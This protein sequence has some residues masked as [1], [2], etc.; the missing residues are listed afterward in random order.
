MAPMNLP[1]TA[2]RVDLPVSRGPRYRAAMCAL[3]AALSIGGPAAAVPPGSTTAAESLAQCERA[4]DLTGEQR[5]QALARGMA[6]AEEALAADDHDAR[7]H[8]ATVCNLGKQMED[9]GLGIGQLISLPRLRRSMD[10]AIELAPGDPDA[11]VAKGALLLELPRLFG[12]DRATAETLLRRALAAEPD[13]NTAR[14]FLARALAQR[15]ADDEARA[16]SPHC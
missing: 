8:Y 2:S 13:N 5:A 12:G 3:V 7:A 16:L 11:L 1:R 9:A 4:D 10:A 14:C 15:G 6:L